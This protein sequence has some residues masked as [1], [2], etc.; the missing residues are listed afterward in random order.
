MKVRCHQGSSTSCDQGKGGA[1]DNSVYRFARQGMMTQLQ[2]LVY[3]MAG[4]ESQAG[5]GGD[6]GSAWITQLNRP[7]GL[8]VNPMT[9]DVYVADSGNNRIRLIFSQI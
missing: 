4:R 7:S 1:R 2:G 8:G 9:K 6:Q 5:F 3:V